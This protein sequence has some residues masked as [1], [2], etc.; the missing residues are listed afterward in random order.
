MAAF[1]LLLPRPFDP[2][3]VRNI[4]VISLCFFSLSCSFVLQR[5]SD[6]CLP[7]CHVRKYQ[8][9]LI[10]PREGIVLWTELDDYCDKLV[11]DRRSS[12]VLSTQLID[13]GPVYYALSVHLCRAKSI[14]R[15]DDRSAEAKFSQSRLWDKVPDGKYPDFCRYANFFKSQYRTGRKKPP[16]QK[17]D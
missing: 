13:D 16:S 9:S 8:L 6:F 10:D 15:F 3:T 4:I 11:D 5:F 2:C 1:P 14:T 17:A 12:E 7:L